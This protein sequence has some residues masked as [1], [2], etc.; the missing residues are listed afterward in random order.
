MVNK[1]TRCRLLDEWF[2]NW[3]KKIDESEAKTKV[4]FVTGQKQG[5]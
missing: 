1:M 3:S 2:D 5:K 4:N